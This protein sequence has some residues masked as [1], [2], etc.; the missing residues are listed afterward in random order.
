MGRVRHVE[1]AAML[2]PRE[3]DSSPS[4]DQAETEQ[5]TQRV[6][7]EHAGA[8]DGESASHPDDT[9]EEQAEE[10]EKHLV[11][12]RVLA[13]HEAWFDV[14][15][16]Y[17]YA[18]RTFPGYAEFH[19]HGEKY[20]LV[21]RAK[22]WEVDNHEY[23]FFVLAD[24][25]EDD[26]LAELIEFMKT[27]AMEKVDP[28]PNHM[29]SCLSLVV[30]ADEVSEEAWRLA[31]KARYRKDFALGLR[32]WAD[33]RVAVVDLATHRVRTNAAGKPMKETLEANIA[34]PRHSEEES[35]GTE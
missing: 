18:G 33:L 27:S 14:S 15:R 22:M 19:S 20:V 24:R 6:Q 28:E 26:G 30:I 5:S 23:I 9:T 4:A 31:R 34:L 10:D 3:T 17:T 2:Q 16:D 32:G 29:S 12:K 21:Q 1:D 7:A 35:E 8:G 25:L 13:A 11:L